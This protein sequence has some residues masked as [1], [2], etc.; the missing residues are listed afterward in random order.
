VSAAVLPNA[1][2]GATR[3][4][5]EKQLAAALGPAKGVW[6]RLLTDLARRF[7]V[8][9]REWKSYSAKAGWSLRLM[10]GKRTILWLAPCRGAIRAAVILGDRAVEAARE[11]GLPKRVLAALDAAT[12]YPEG[13]AVRFE[14]KTATGIGT[15]T[16]LAEIKL[17]H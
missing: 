1:F 3:K 17:A 5:T 16:R 15:I 14:F 2:I 11:S 13:T 7:G 8:T 12:R 10:R 6:D 4:P 9:G